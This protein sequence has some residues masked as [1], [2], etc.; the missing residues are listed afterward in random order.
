MVTIA[1][2]KKKKQKTQNYGMFLNLNL[3]FKLAMLFLTCKIKLHY[4]TQ[5]YGAHPS[6]LLDQHT[7]SSKSTCLEIYDHGC[8]WFMNKTQLRNLRL[9]FLLHFHQKINCLTKF[10]IFYSK[11]KSKKT[12]W[13]SI[14]SP[15]AFQIFFHPW[16][17]SYDQFQELVAS[18]CNKFTSVGPLIQE[19][20][21][22]FIL[23]GASGYFQ[24]LPYLSST[25]QHTSLFLTRHPTTTG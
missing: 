12:I 9:V 18:R 3:S 15:K 22:Q 5:V 17:T 10:K 4:V 24:Y 20:I 21:A 8:S 13:A 25:N 14:Y 1:Y 19:S 16:S 6:N 7:H 2:M 11:Q 23:I